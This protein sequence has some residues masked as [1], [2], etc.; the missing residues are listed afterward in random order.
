MCVFDLWCYSSCCCR[1]NRL[2]VPSR[3]G[4]ISTISRVIHTMTTATSVGGRGLQPAKSLHSL[5]PTHHQQSSEQITTFGVDDRVHTTNS[6][7]RRGGRQPYNDTTYNDAGYNR[8]VLYKAVAPT[9]TS[10]M[11]TRKPPTQSHDQT[12]AAEAVA[13]RTASSSGAS[14]RRVGDRS[15]CPSQA[16]S[17]FSSLSH[18]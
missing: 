12:T 16:N 6:M 2:A 8:N 3:G 13:I 1:Y 15:V 10:F 17:S 9:V 18:R 5:Y 7:A 4:D 14:M 11:L